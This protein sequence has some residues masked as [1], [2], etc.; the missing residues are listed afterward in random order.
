MPLNILFLDPKRT[1]DFKAQPVWVPPPATNLSA[2]VRSF[3][4]VPNPDQLCPGDLLLY[5][6]HKPDWISARIVSTQKKAFPEQHARWHHA[7][8]YIK[9]MWVCEAELFGVSY[10]R[11]FDDLDGITRIRVRRPDYA[12]LNGRTGISEEK[13][14]FELVVN[15]M[16]R[17]SVPYGYWKAWDL[18]RQAQ[19]SF[20][21]PVVKYGQARSVICSELYAEAYL[22]ATN[23]LPVPNHPEIPT[24]AHLSSS[25]SFH[26]VAVGWRPIGDNYI[27]V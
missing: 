26:E 19:S 2:E 1:G 27:S 8:M 17:I 24:P 16:S 12:G 7:A 14:Q 22:K 18:F 23:E 25:T 6:S 15:A 3:G 13:I 9:D 20:I 11:L 21:S 4:Y 10:R 5:S